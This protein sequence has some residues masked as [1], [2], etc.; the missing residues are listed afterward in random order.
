MTEISAISKFYAIYLKEY[1]QV[2]S[3]KDKMAIVDEALEKR[4]VAEEE[5]SKRKEL[6]EKQKRDQ[7]LQPGAKLTEV[8]T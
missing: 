8:S 1:L 7:E 2:V 6:L 3:I 5:S 4:Q